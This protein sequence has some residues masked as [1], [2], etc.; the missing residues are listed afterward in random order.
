[1]LTITVPQQFERR[2]RQLAAASGHAPEAYLRFV[3]NAGLEAMEEAQEAYAASERIARGEES[4]CSSRELRVEL[5]LKSPR[6]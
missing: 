4:T 1:M 2:V 5:G 6:R 3:M